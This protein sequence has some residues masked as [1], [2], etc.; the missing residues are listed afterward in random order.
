M[1]HVSLLFRLVVFICNV[2]V[3]IFLL[4]WSAILWLP[5]WWSSLFALRSQCVFERT[6]YSWQ[7]NSEL[8]RF[9]SLG[10]STMDTL[11]TP[12]SAVNVMLAGRARR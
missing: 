8:D 3:G 1:F 12:A 2:P 10:Q 11:A 7:T 6:P 9:S 4:I 5:S